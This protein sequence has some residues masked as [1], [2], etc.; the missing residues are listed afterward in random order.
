MNYADRCSSD[1]SIKN[2]CCCSWFCRMFERLAPKNIQMSFT[3]VCESALHACVPFVSKMLS[4]NMQF[5]RI[6]LWK[7]IYE[8][9]LKFTFTLLEN[10]IHPTRTVLFRKILSTKHLVKFSHHFLSCD[11]IFDTC[12][13]KRVT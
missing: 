9:P 10:I 12:G 3:C 6:F 1:C 7:G 11:K 8:Q 4:Q 13:T 5:S 2:L